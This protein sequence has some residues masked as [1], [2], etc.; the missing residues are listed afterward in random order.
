MNRALLACLFLLPGCS[1]R[2]PTNDGADDLDTSDSDAETSETTT[3]TT[4]DGDGD[5]STSTT[6]DGDGDGDTSTTTGDGDGDTTSSTT[7]DGDGDTTGDGDGDT[8]TGD[9]DSCPQAADC[10]ELLTAFETETLAIRGCS[11]DDQCGQVLQGT[12][13]GC[14]RDWVA[15]LDADT[16]CF[17]SLIDQAELLQ[18]DLGLG[19]TCD[20][21]GADGYACVDG[22]CTWNYL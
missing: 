20:C 8:T 5:T 12:S 16:T 18:C 4:G 3:T 13:C 19:S 15:R 7:G 9:G 17:Y 6:G 11:G 2:E 22:T 1:E 10:N 14:T 21:P